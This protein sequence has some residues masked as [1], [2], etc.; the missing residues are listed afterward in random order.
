LLSV[1]VRRW[2]LRI[3]EASTLTLGDL[4]SL[5][6][7]LVPRMSVV[8]RSDVIDDDGDTQAM[9]AAEDML[10]EGCLSGALENVSDACDHCV[11]Y[12]WDR[13]GPNLPESPKAGSPGESEESV[14]VSSLLERK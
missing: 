14:T 1:R 2:L 4:V 9:L 7:D 8:L 6:K 11:S 3:V 12:R 10:E 13:I 5:L